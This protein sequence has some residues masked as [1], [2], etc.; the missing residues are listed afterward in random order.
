MSGSTLTEMIRG[1]SIEKKK[2]KVGASVTGWR[3]KVVCEFL[4]GVVDSKRMYLIRDRRGGR[5]LMVVRGGLARRTMDLFWLGMKD[6]DH[7]GLLR[8]EKS[9]EKREEAEASSSVDGLDHARGSG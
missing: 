5:A 2:S 9:K 1:G 8:K 4:N 6:R 3:L 7:R